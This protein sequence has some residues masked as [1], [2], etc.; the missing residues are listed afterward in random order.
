V[1]GDASD[2]SRSRKTLWAL[3]KYHHGPRH[4]GRCG[5]SARVILHEL[6]GSMRE[7]RLSLTKTLVHVLTR[8]RLSGRMCTDSW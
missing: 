2:R 4:R 3:T 1:E 8:V 7:V 5:R 6:S